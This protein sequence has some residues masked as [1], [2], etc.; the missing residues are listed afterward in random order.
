M[1]QFTRREAHILTRSSPSRLAYLAKTGIV[2]PHRTDSPS[3]PT[4]F[5]TWDQILEI[6]AI[7]RLRRQV[8]F[9]T[10]RKIIRFLEEQGFDRSLRDKLLITI[11]GDVSWILPL[12]AAAPPA[13]QAQVI[14]AQVIQAQVIQIVGK[15]RCPA[16][17]LLLAAIPQLLDL[18]DELGKIAKTATVI[19]FEYFKQRLRSP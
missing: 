8:S 12:N 1:E 4:L 3:R 2:V 5:Y 9:Q 10:I 14:Q 19:D 13:M 6:R 18:V 16:G 7:N 17:Q 11:G 15:R